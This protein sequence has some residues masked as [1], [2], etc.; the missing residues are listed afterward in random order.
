MKSALFQKLASLPGINWFNNK[1][2]ISRPDPTPE[3]RLEPQEDDSHGRLYRL[4]SKYFRKLVTQDLY[5]QEL[6]KLLDQFNFEVEKW[7]TVQAGHEHEIQKMKLECDRR[8][9]DIQFQ[10]HNSRNGRLHNEI[11][12]LSAKVRRQENHINS[13][14][15]RKPI[16][17]D[18]KAKDFIK[19]IG[20]LM[21]SIKYNK[22]HEVGRIRDMAHRLDALL[23]KTEDV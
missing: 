13:L 9:E 16:L 17:S 19:A 7:D 21:D 10:M 3:M 2:K 20:A 4:S 14:E 8:I 5:I 11:Q 15:K 18:H 12:Q 6:H 23:R 22:N 1:E